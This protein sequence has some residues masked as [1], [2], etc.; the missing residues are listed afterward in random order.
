MAATH[1]EQNP[2][3]KI[4]VVNKHGENL[5]GLLHETGSNEIVVLCHGFQSSKLSSYEGVWHCFSECLSEQESESTF[6]YGN[7]HREADDLHAVI[8]HFHE[9][10]RVPRAILRH[11]KGEN[12]V[13]L[14]ASKYH[15]VH[16]VTN[17]SGHYKTEGG[18]EELLGKG[19][20]QKVKEKGFIDVKATTCIIA[21]EFLK[22]SYQMCNRVIS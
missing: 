20:F 1:F 18:V 7:Y 3:Q 2:G 10:N 19:Y 16:R 13:L 8:Q 21:D 6:H 22:H 14:Y 9:A 5:V 4:V 15:D 11:S 12:V 17:V